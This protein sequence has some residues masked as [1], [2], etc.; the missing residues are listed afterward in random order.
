MHDTNY[1]TPIMTSLKYLGLCSDQ[2]LENSSST[3]AY[4]LSIWLYKM[5]IIWVFNENLKIMNL[6]CKVYMYSCWPTE[7]FNLKNGQL[8]FIMV[9]GI[10][11]VQIINIGFYIYMQATKLQ[12]IW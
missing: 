1:D 4:M 11:Y 8:S 3:T 9:L 2:G 7:I 10:D 6:Y 12:E 5:G